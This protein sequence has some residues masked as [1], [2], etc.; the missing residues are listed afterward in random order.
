MTAVKSL[1]GSIPHPRAERDGITRW[2]CLPKL[3]INQLFLYV[4]PADFSM[5]YLYNLFLSFE[6]LFFGVCSRQTKKSNVIATSTL[7][8]SIWILIK[9]CRK[10]MGV[11]LKTFCLRL[12]IAECALWIQTEKIFEIIFLFWEICVCRTA[13]AR[14][15]YQWSCAKNSIGLKLCTN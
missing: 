15:P 2:I 1:S 10:Y 12:W 7:S 8:L 9:S 4:T 11:Y 6:C 14:K 3:K 13:N 5:V